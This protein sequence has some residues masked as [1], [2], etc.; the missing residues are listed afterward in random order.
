MASGPAGTSKHIFVIEVKECDY[1]ILSRSLLDPLK[2]LDLMSSYVFHRESKPQ[3]LKVSCDDLD[4]FSEERCNILLKGSQ[5]WIW[6]FEGFIEQLAGQLDDVGVIQ[7]WRVETYDVKGQTPYTVV[8]WTLFMYDDDPDSLA[9][10]DIL[11]SEEELKPQ[12]E[13]PS[14]VTMDVSEQRR[15]R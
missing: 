12:D 2:G 6:R 3:R 11:L 14:H 5:D 13:E 15:E 7:K 10:N 4:H 1:S 8:T 9:T